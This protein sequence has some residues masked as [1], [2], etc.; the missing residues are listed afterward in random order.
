M[1]ER[2]PERHQGQAFGAKAGFE[3][4]LQAWADKMG[5]A[6]VEQEDQGSSRRG[7]ADLA[8]KIEDLFGGGSAGNGLESG[9]PQPRQ[10]SVQ[11]VGDFRGH[12]SLLGTCGVQAREV[13]GAV[14][15][16]EK[17][18]IAQ[19]WH[20]PIFYFRGFDFNPG[21]ARCEPPGANNG[22]AAEMD[23]F[24]AEGRGFEPLVS[25][26]TTDFKSAAIDHSASPPQD[27]IITSGKG[28][29]EAGVR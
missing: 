22:P 1:P 3:N 23:G 10:C 15:V 5:L 13:Q 20:P 27:D 17:K 11:V 26:P 4:R 19:V 18:E 8:S 12:G 25:H 14:R 29:G 28:I 2:A 24:L 7:F 16:V 6:S 9:V 21:K